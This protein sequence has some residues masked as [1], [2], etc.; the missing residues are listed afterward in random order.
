[1]GNCCGGTA[2]VPSEPAPQVTQK[3]TLTP[4]L[5]QFTTESPV[6]SSSPPSRTLSRVA[7][8]PESAHQPLLPSSQLPTRTRSRAASKPESTP[9]SR[10]SSKV[11]TPEV[12][13][14]LHH[15][16]SNP[17]SRHR[18]RLGLGPRRFPRL[19]GV[20]APILDLR[21]QVSATVSGL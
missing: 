10:V 17:R 15:S 18:R 3:T 14:S 4:V 16:R 21:T 11:Q 5:S 7:S 19:Q 9:H 6:P 12:G 8:E 2:T 20:V 13:R 1:M